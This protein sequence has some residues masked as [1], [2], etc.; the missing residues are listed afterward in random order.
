MSELQKLANYLNEHGIEYEWYSVM[1]G[2]PDQIAVPSKKNC[3]WDAIC[4]CYSYGG[5]RG[6]LEI[7]GDILTNEDREYDSVVGYLTAED[8][9]TRIEMKG[10]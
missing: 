3:Q 9:I 7:M 10:K 2:A 4:H 6:L 8:V 1:G 5:T